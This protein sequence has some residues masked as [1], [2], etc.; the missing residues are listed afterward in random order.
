M[1]TSTSRN[2]ILKLFS[3]KTPSVVV[4]HFQQRNNVKNFYFLQFSANVFFLL[5]ISQLQSR[6]HWTLKKKKKK[7]YQMCSINGPLFFSWRGG[8]VSVA[9]SPA[10]IA[11]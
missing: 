11:F 6:C 8:A 3:S 7:E 5:S 9:P 2:S 4:L 1:N 10:T